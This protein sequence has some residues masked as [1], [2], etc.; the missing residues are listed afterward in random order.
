M[1]ALAPRPYLASSFR[2]GCNQNKP[3][4]VFLRDGKYTLLLDFF[5]E[6][7]PPTGPKMDWTPAGGVGFGY[8]G[9]EDMRDNR[10]L[11][12]MVNK[13]DPNREF[14]IIAQTQRNGGKTAFQ[15]GS[16]DGSN[17]LMGKN[18]ERVNITRVKM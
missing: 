11:A 5:C 12:K 6:K 8:A 7:Q 1:S 10:N 17:V 9:N 14:V 15:V 4:N 18:G 3:G 2:E 13:I 16:F